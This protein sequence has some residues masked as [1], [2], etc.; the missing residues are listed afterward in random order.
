M[1]DIKITE[2]EAKKIE[3]EHC[4]ISVISNFII[5]YKK[6]TENTRERRDFLK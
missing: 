4:P 5:I 6:N 1:N 2:V 3:Q